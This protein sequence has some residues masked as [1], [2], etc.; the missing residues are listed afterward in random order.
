M[1]ILNQYEIDS[2]DK[3]A[4]EYNCQVLMPPVNGSYN[5]FLDICGPLD[6]IGLHKSLFYRG[7]SFSSKMIND[8]SY[9]EIKG[10]C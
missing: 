1:N 4:E 7:F 2:L 6:I 8:K 5:I 10:R 3:L 9:I